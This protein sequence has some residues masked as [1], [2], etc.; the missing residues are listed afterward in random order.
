MNSKHLVAAGTLL[1]VLTVVTVLSQRTSVDNAPAPEPALAPDTQAKRATV[2]ASTPPELADSADVLSERQMQLLED[3]RV[4]R[5]SRD[6]EFQEQVSDFFDQASHM[7]EE[8]RAQQAAKIENQ[9]KDYRTQGK[10]SGSEA[11]LLRLALVR[12]VEQDPQQQEV[13][14][15]ALIQE[16]QREAE[17]RMAQWRSR[18]QP[19]FDRYKQEERSIVEEVMAM[20]K[21]PGGME[22][23]EYLR[24]RLQQARIEAMGEQQ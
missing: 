2:A 22:R 11:L 17:Q 1:V 12:T 3:P 21:I 8:E 7:S 10:V 13:E 4:I 6:L 16:Y 18:N 14:S 19:E 23:N 20:E 5:F 9:L 15:R 24:Q